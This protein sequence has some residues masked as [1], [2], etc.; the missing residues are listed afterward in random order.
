ME[1][2]VLTLYNIKRRSHNIAH[3]N[4]V[5]I[6]NRPLRNPPHVRNRR[7]NI[8]SNGRHQKGLRTKAQRAYH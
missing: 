8:P 7:I 5:C 1:S 2:A 4:I 3:Q 6:M